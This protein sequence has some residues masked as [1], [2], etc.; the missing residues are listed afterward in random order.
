SMFG[1]GLGDFNQ[2][3]AP[4]DPGYAQLDKLMALEITRNGEKPPP[5]LAWRTRYFRA[6]LEKEFGTPPGAIMI[7]HSDLATHIPLPRKPGEVVYRF[8]GALWRLEWITPEQVAQL[9]P[10]RQHT[11]AFSRRVALIQNEI[12]DLPFPEVEGERGKNQLRPYLPKR[13][14]VVR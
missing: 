14:P 2:P 12:K 10:L 5:P 11:T 4:P 8:F 13:Q 6:S 1:L 3:I 7:A 9:Q